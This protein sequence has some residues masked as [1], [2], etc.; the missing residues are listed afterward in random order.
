M[1]SHLV[2][3]SPGIAIVI[4]AYRAEK[5][6]QKILSG[7]PSFVSHI[8]VVNDCSPDCTAELVEAS[9]DARVC[10]VSHEKNQGVGAAMITGYRKAIELG[11]TII[12]KMDSDDQ[13]D[14]AYLIPLIAPILLGKVDYTKGNRFLHANELKSMP[15]IRRLGNAGLSFLT[16]AASGYWNIFDPTNGYTAIHSSLIPLLDKTRIH[17]RYFF[18]SSMLIEL[19]MHRAVI[20]DVY[21]PARYGDG[22]SS[23]SVWKTLI[24]FPPRLLSAF[25]R[26]FVVQY[27]IRDFGIVSVLFL[28]GLMFSA[29]GV[30]YGGYH[31]YVSAVS[32]NVAPTGTVMVATLPLIVGS[33][34]L[35]QALV[36]D[37]QSIPR[38]PIHSQLDALDRL[39]QALSK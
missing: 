27:F 31:W 10:L 3:G 23:L 12:V 2:A 28:M 14:P 32:G 26:R 36:T 9:N 30:I 5:F 6:I 15:F 39:Y 21:I 17:P 38:E 8:I 4:P 25:L 29:F 1:D 18:E 19:G 35:I 16:K 34:L 37:I 7:I 22:F 20:R 33:Q 11:A 13:M 24:E